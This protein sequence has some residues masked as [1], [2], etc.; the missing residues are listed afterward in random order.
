VIKGA[1][2]LPDWVATMDRL[3]A[4]HRAITMA[5]IAGD[6]TSA[7]TRIHDHISGYYAESHLA[8]TARSAGTTPDRRPDHG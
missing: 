4:E 6:G 5:I 1:T 7:A 3:R 8:S 2:T